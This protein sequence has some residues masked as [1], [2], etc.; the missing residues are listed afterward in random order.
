MTSLS[1]QGNPL[2]DVDDIKKEVLIVMRHLTRINDEDVTKE[3][4]Q[5]AEDTLNERRE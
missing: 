3:E 1:V 4:L 2:Q 5:I